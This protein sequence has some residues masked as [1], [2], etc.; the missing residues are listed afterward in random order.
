MNIGPNSSNISPDAAMASAQ[1]YYNNTITAFDNQLEK[2]KNKDGEI[3]G[4]AAVACMNIIKDV[5][6]KVVMPTEREKLFNDLSEHLKTFEATCPKA[7]Q[8][9]LKNIA[10]YL[11]QE[12]SSR[13][14]NILSTEPEF[15]DPM[16]KYL[17]A[18]DQYMLLKTQ[19]NDRKEGKEGNVHFDKYIQK[20]EKQSIKTEYVANSDIQIQKNILL[21]KAKEEAIHW[22][23]ISN[24][25][26]EDIIDIQDG[27]LEGLIQTMFEFK[28]KEK[29][30]KKE[31][32]I[33][34]DIR[35]L[36]PDLLD[37]YSDIKNLEASYT[38]VSLISLLPHFRKLELITL[39]F[40]SINTPSVIIPADIQNLTHLKEL[41]IRGPVCELPQTLTSMKEL[42]T[43]KVNLKNVP[44]WFGE[45]QSLRTLCV[46]DLDQF[47]NEFLKLQNL[48]VLNLHN[49]HC[50]PED[51]FEKLPNLKA[52]VLANGNTFPRH[53]MN[54]YKAYIRSLAVD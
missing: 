8:Q 2:L 16:F 29:A 25:G 11:N 26:G 45:M 6:N 3:R 20:K 48:E 10:S 17:S 44:S 31:S 38:H 30:L 9:K 54:R 5:G 24:G 21:E 4:D 53:M 1:K 19:E 42:H 32:L 23:R 28:N 7:L 49:C 18:I 40:N 47:S 13:L 22:L 35:N 14:D 50:A 12:K 43:L 41:N 37:V 36:P 39:I 33:L 27:E 15:V 52:L 51:L 34:R 46:E